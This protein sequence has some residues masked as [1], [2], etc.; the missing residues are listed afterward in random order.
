M[1]SKFNRYTEVEKFLFKQLPMFQRVGPKA[2]KKD[3][4]NI[5]YLSKQLAH[6]HKNFKSIHIAGTNGKGSCSFFIATA[7]HEMG[8][9][10]GLY[11]SPHYRTYRERIK[12]N[13]EMIPKYIVKSFVNDLTEKGIFQ[14]EFRPSFFEISV[15]L[16]FKYFSDKKVDYAVIETGLG[17]RLDSTNIISPILSLITNIGLDHTNF[18]GNTLKKIAKEKAGIIKSNTP[19]VIGRTQNETE[20]VFIAKARQLKAPITF[21]DKSKS[22]IPNDFTS[23][24]PEYQRE[25]MNSALVVLKEL[26]L[27]ISRQ[28]IKRAWTKRLKTWGYIGRFQFISQQPRVLVDSAHNIDGISILLKEI[29]NIKYSNL[30]IVL[31]MVG[32]KDVS[33]VLSLLPEKASYYFAEAKI[34]R[35]M[36]VNKLLA[37]ADKHNL[38]GKSYTSVKRALAAAKRKASKSDMVLVTGSIFTVAE[39]V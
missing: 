8:Y 27:E 36:K 28:S 37:A 30:H 21:A 31:A 23:A 22:T 34:P 5:K 6:P 19:V 13:G 10:V 15:A 4:K 26:R 32:D 2:F 1:K 35:A 11:T 9:K 25:N 3:L 16:A 14:S 39:V 7:L 12:I 18:L 29:E 38:L 24:F 33:K 20:E 17:G